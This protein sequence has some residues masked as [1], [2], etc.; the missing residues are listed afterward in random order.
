MK[1]HGIYLKLRPE[2]A[3][4][5]MITINFAKE[6]AEEYVE[7]YQRLELLVLECTLSSKALFLRDSLVEME[8]LCRVISVT[9]MR[10]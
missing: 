10:V 9:G 6:V 1:K 4:T 7:V 5:N 3:Q 2:I 8:H